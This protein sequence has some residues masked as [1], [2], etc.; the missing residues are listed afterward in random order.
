MLLIKCPWCGARAETE[1]S[2]GGEA[3]I[4]RP[5]EPDKLSDKEWPDYLLMPKNPRC[6]HR[7]LWNHSQVG[8]RWVGA[9]RNTVTYQIAD[10]FTLS[11]E[12]G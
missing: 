11:E 2:Y 10:I 12:S 4:K 9:E 6:T 5:E 7:E 3:D 1:F 8:R